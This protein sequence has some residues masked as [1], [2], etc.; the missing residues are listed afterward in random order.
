MTQTLDMGMTAT[1][2]L[3]GT[4]T[5]ALKA[6]QPIFVVLERDFPPDSI[7]RADLVARITD[8][9]SSAL[10]ILP[11]R[12]QLLGMENGSV[13]ATFAIAD[14]DGESPTAH[15]T[16]KVVEDYWKQVDDPS[17]AL[18]QGQETQFLNRD[19]TMQIKTEA[20]D[21]LAEWSKDF[22][23]EHKAG[24]TLTLW[25]HGEQTV[26]VTVQDLL[27]EG[28]CGK[29]YKVS[30]GEK[31]CALKAYQATHGFEQLCEEA[32]LLLQLNYPLSHR[33]VL[34]M[35]F[36][37]ARDK[38][39]LFL[40]GYVDGGDLQQWVVEERLYQGTLLDQQ[41]RLRMVSA[42]IA[43]GLGHLHSCGILHSDVKPENVLMTA[44]GVPVLADMGV[45]APGSQTETAAG[46]EVQA[47]MKGGTSSFCSPRMK[48]VF[49]RLKPMKHAD[50]QSAQQLG[51]NLLSHSDDLWC[52]AA[53]V[54]DMH[55][56]VL[57]R[58][59]HLI[60]DM[61]KDDGSF[62]TIPLR[63]TMQH[64]V[65][66]LLQR[67]FAANPRMT[68]R[69]IAQ[70]LGS[71]AVASQASAISDTYAATINVNLGNALHDRGIYHQAEKQYRRSLQI[72]PGDPRSLNNLGVALQARPRGR[73]LLEEAKVQFE[74][75]LEADGSHIQANKNIARGRLP[76]VLD[77]SGTEAAVGVT[78]PKI[79][80]ETA[81]RY[82]IGQRARIRKH[83]RWE[84]TVIT[85]HD[86]CHNL[87]TNSHFTA[88]ATTQYE[89]GQLLRVKTT[90]RKNE[91][92]RWCEVVQQPSKP[93]F[94][95]HDLR[96]VDAV[97]PNQAATVRLE[98]NA[99]NH[100]PALLM[101][102][103]YATAAE[104]YK[105]Y[106]Q[107]RSAYIY[108]IF[109]Q[110]TLD[111]CT[112]TV[113]LRYCDGQ[114][115]NRLFASDFDFDNRHNE[116]GSAGTA[117]ADVS[118]I[119]GK[120]LGSAPQWHDGKW[121]INGLLIV[122]PAASGKTTVLKRFSMEVLLQHFPFIVP[123][124]IPV[125]ELVPILSESTE[126]DGRIVFNYLAR[127]F[128]QNPGH[129]RLVLQALSERS[130]LVMID[131]MDESGSFRPQVEK[132]VAEELLQRGQRCIT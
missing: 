108:D 17:S 78:H 65:E 36:V 100:A 38:Q 117:V 66:S 12:I 8:D 18:Y 82:A 37:Q 131:G 6:L 26:Q 70:T 72:R 120:L 74:A 47:I 19:R 98:L 61:I 9:L 7:K 20:L 24:E 90:G 101:A 121:S 56:E 110:K 109:S 85:N 14:A 23:S 22:A 53:T 62:A 43:S 13:I 76:G 113:S 30:Y 25:Q 41:R 29:V 127:K 93:D 64:D 58:A 125:I 95:E 57:W 80:L 73:G 51:V 116:R 16:A 59:G 27:G 89:A 104:A 96:F 129:C 81:V 91:Q 52:F 33:N 1:L 67:C 5:H 84:G 39:M 122:G 99:T 87:C 118:D 103:E 102:T 94:S 75:A 128:D 60:S 63:V 40:L 88:G 44:R 92:W 130:A 97:E 15:P 50:R 32:S 132:F 11:I 86:D 54:L 28:A 68:A 2:R 31:V 35:D 107:D 105:I 10:D 79:P 69:Q 114:R 34:S 21:P 3:P 45:S 42:G 124:T 71:P 4:K 49:W 55:G 46:H 119:L 48:E 77:R 115:R 126:S 106:L 111:V 112:Q 123:L 83:G